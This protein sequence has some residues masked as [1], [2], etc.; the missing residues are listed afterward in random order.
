MTPHREFF[1]QF[2]EI[3]GGSVFL[4]DNKACGIEGIGSV[5]IKMHDV[6]I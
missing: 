5:R 4:G 1:Y 3:K 2:K 6:V